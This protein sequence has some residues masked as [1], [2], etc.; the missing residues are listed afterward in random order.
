MTVVV[1]RPNGL[2]APTS[3]FVPW[4]TL[5]KTRLA[6]R[7]GRVL[8][9]ALSVLGVY[10]AGRGLGAD[11]LTV[12][13]FL[14][15][16]WLLVLRFGRFLTPD[17]LGAVAATATGAMLGLGVVAQTPLWLPPV[18]LSPAR[19]LAMA[20]VVLVFVGT[21]ECVVQHTTA[22]RRRV[23][24]VGAPVVADALARET[25]RKDAALDVLGMVPERSE[26]CETC[27]VPVLGELDGLSGVIEALQ[28]DVVVV[29][30]GT[31]CDSAVDRLLDVPRAGFRV[32]GVTSF[33]E[34]AFGR[35]PVSE[36]HASWFVG[37]LH[38]RQH[39]YARWSKRAFDIGAAAV[40]L[41]LAAPI[42][43]LVA[44]LLAPSGKVLYRQTRLGEGGRLFTIVKFRT[45]ADGAEAPGRAM[46]SVDDDPRVTRL[47]RILRRAH[48]DEL[49]QLLNVLRGDMSMVGPRPERPEFVDL[50]EH[51][52]PFWHRR[53]LVKPG[54]TGWAQL[55]SGYASDCEAMADKLS[56]DLWYLR[57][58]T[59]LV[60]VA[61][62]AATAL[63]MLGALLPVH[64]DAR[65]SGPAD[66]GAR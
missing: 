12:V 47:G 41:M 17:A 42:M 21:W 62:C 13:G 23:L 14:T 35:V 61:I 34:H 10:S 38:L 31:E 32:V 50:L 48:L 40:A 49:P 2:A 46:W 44:L 58:R 63:Q 33:F 15:G 7:A 4:Q 66:G 43:A 54:V 64:R 29:A 45:M 16:V 18:E 5:R 11:G 22:A 55:K 24:V 20:G 52:V 25:A 56:Y 28:P 53:L 3:P 26:E 51:E 8:L 36:L 6:A 9:V 27:D 65:V 59:V 39:A 30:D 1:E 57:N 19:S 60:D 37:L